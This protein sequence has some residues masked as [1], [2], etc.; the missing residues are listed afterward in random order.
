MK[1]VFF[2]LGLLYGDGEQPSVGINVNNSSV[3]GFSVIHGN[4]V[5]VHQTPLDEDGRR[6]LYSRVGMADQATVHWPYPAK[7]YSEGTDPCVAVQPGVGG[8]IAANGSVVEVHKH[9]RESRLF[10]MIGTIRIDGV[11]WKD[12]VEY[13][14][15]VTPAVAVND[16]GTVVEVHKSNNNFGLWF[17]VGEVGSDSVV[18]TFDGRY[19][20]GQRP[21]VAINNNDEVVEVHQAKD[22]D[23]LWYSVGPIDEDN[24]KIAFG[25]STNF[26]SSGTNPSVA[27]TDDGSV[28]VV[29]AVGE[30]LMQRF[31][32]LDM[33]EKQIT[34]TGEAVTY[35]GGI[36]PFVAAAGRLSIEVHRGKS[37]K[38]WFS[39]S[40][41]TD[42]ARWMAA[43]AALKTRKMSQ[44]VLPASH[45]AGMYPEGLLASWARTQDLTIGQQL[46]YGIRYFDLRPK[47]T[48]GEFFLHHGGV[49]GAKL[50]EVLA[51]I[52]AYATVHKELIIIKFSHFSGFDDD[53]DVYVK[54]ATEVETSIKRWMVKPPLPDGKRL[55]D[56]TLGA[57]T[58]MGT[59]IVVAVDDEDEAWAL[60]PKTKREGFWVFRNW[61]AKDAYIGDL[62]VFDQYSNTKD[63]DEMKGDQ[64]LKFAAYDGKLLDSPDL[65]CDLFLL[66]WTLTPVTGVESLSAN[67]NRH[68]GRVMSTLK[69]PNGY[70]KIT[71]LLYVDF[72]E[73]A[74]VTDV[75]IIQNSQT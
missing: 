22:Q 60:K 37:S 63:Y 65:P 16:H 55:A 43:T 70:G 35:D 8:D 29:Y 51:A 52:S 33:S 53:G 54:F 64:L 72:V 30:K 18:W 14:L 10:C 17:R 9:T 38:T 39:T 6:W 57:Y 44:L 15:G 68:L 41:I 11:E 21:R 59:A 2:G 34:W 27:L 23:S 5:A 73:F 58:S 36:T 50:G 4:V 61:E 47:W 71:N 3:N 42:R 31:G 56:I 32:Q 49:S 25:T 45:D 40:L 12:A 24:R 19:H 74:R 75:A 13:T 67:A 46:E 26:A 1:N 69:D 7:N 28:I 62:C 48:S 20:E 66:S